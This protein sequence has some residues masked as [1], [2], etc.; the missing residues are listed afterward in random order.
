V[1]SKVE[2]KEQVILY[3]HVK[4]INFPKL[5]PNL[6]FSPSISKI[7]EITTGT[8]SP[9]EPR[10]L[11]FPHLPEGEMRDG[12]PAL[13]RYSS[14]LTNGHD[15]PGA[16]AMF[17]AAG[18]PDKEAMRSSPHIGIGS[19]WWEGNPCKYANPSSGP[20]R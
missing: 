11:Q 18:V 10:Y 15:F 14:I 2:R 3:L 19:V 7:M 20:Y 16:K 9:E 12:K 8:D 6:T 17:Y 4:Y 5:L 13:N 1:T